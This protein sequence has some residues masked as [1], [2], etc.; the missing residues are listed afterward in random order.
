[1]GFETDLFCVSSEREKTYIVKDFGY[2][3]DEV[4]VTGLPRF[5]ALFDTDVPVEP[6]QIL[7]IPTWRDWL[8]NEE[9]FID[10]DYFQQWND[11]LHDPALAQLVQENQLEL[12]FCLRPN[13]QHLRSYFVS[14]PVRIVAQGE[15]DV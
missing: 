12:I 3:P 10:S 7:I 2:D 5:D 14:A 15:V 6:R 13:M 9:G 4:V 11:F 1:V 8:Q